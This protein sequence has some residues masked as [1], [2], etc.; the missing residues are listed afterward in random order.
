VVLKKGIRLRVMITR[1]LGA[2]RRMDVGSTYWDGA[3]ASYGGCLLPHSRAPV[4]AAGLYPGRCIITGSRGCC[5]LS[6]VTGDRLVF[7]TSASG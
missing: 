7:A 3:V 1:R 2:W 6:Q 4:V 5:A